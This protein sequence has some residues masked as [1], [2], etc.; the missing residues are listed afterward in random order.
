MRPQKYDQIRHR[1]LEYKQ[2]VNE[3]DFQAIHRNSKKSR[4]KE[5]GNGHCLLR[6]HDRSD[7]MGHHASV[8]IHRVKALLCCLL[9]FAMLS[10]CALIQTP[11]SSLAKANEHLASE[12]ASFHI[13]LTVISESV[14]FAYR[15]DIHTADALASWSGQANIHAYGMTFQQDC[16]TYCTAD[17]S[18]KLWRD[19][20]VSSDNRSPALMLRSWL[21]RVSSGSGKY[22]KEPAIPE[23]PSI[24][25]EL[26]YAVQ[27]KCSIPWEKLCDA[28]IDSSFGGQDLLTSFQSAMVT[29]Y[30][31]AETLNLEGIVI[32]QNNG[33]SSLYAVITV[34]T[35]DGHFTDNFPDI[36][37]LPV[38]IL[39]EEWSICTS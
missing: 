36:T 25:Q 27:M 33:S 19:K 13:E 10:G 34:F 8:L 35:T 7:R 14:T 16:Q 29:L 21:Q 30:F 11:R 17:S 37:D 1:R 12:P 22:L 4:Q 9:V 24:S 23:A 38:G 26:C 31:N 20:L 6:R 2:E 3:H 5:P 32:N 39:S 28:H 15:S 18:A